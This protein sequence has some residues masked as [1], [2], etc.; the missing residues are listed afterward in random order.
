MSAKLH[1]DRLT[2]YSHVPN[3][4]I[5]FKNF[6]GGISWGVGSVLGAT[7]II[8]MLAWIL[9]YMDFIPY[10]GDIFSEFTREVSNYSR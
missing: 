6:I 7:V 5:I 8:S 2:A 9:G 4:K 3:H 10:V 1:D